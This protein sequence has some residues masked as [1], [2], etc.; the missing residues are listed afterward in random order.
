MIFS[1]D[2][3]DEVLKLY[4]V[5]HRNEYIVHPDEQDRLLHMTTT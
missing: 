5:S 2:D 4:S 1:A 3:D